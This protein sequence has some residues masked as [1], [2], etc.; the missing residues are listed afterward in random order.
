MAYEAL[1]NPSYDLGTKHIIFISDGDHWN[2]DPALL[3]KIRADKITCTTVV[4]HHARRGRGA[5]DEPPWPRPPAAGSTH[6]T[7]PRRAAGDLHQGDAGWSASRSSTRSRS[8]R[9]SSLPRRPDRRLPDDCRRCTASSAPR[10]KPSPLVE[11]PIVTPPHRRAGFPDPGLLALRPGQGGG[12]HQ[13]RPL[14]APERRVKSVVLVD[15][16]GYSPAEIESAKEIASCLER[17]A[18]KQIH[19]VLPA[20][21][22]RST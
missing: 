12:L 20:S 1:T 17:V 15:T 3:A 9:S 21:M 8:R 10:A 13:R 6:V 7:E 18:N 4:R 11:M 16:P 19:L 2:A 22:K 14:A 5:E